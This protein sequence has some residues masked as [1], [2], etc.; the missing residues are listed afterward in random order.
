VH[1]KQVS[2]ASI[3]GASGI[4]HANTQFGWSSRFPMD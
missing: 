3:S 2:I 4:K 1:Q